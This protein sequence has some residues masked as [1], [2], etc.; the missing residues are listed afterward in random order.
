MLSIGDDFWIENGEG[1]RVFKIDG[2]A[3]RLRK[4]LVFEDTEGRELCR[5]KERVLRVR[6]SMEVEGPDGERL[7]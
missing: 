4:T 6:D 5:I 2:K 3:M 7:A 1:E